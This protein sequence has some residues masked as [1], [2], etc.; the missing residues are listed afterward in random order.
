M[1]PRRSAQWYAGNDRNSYI[2]RAWMRRGL[3]AD[4]FDGRPH[5]AIANTASDL[6][7]C[8]AHLDEV[9]RSVS[10]GIYEAGGIALNLPVVSL[11][12]TQVRP[13]AMLW[14]N[15]AAMATEEMLRANPIDGV[16]LLGGCDKTIPSLLMAAA[17]VD[18]PAVVMP[19]GPMLTGTFR[20]VPLGCGTG[21]WQLS[22]E[23]RA[24]TLSAAEFVRSES[25]MI[26]S[27][28]HCNTMGTASTMGLLAEVLGMTRP[29]VAGIPAPDSRLLEAAHATGVLVVEMIEAG[30]RPSTVLSRGSFLNAIVALAALGGSTNAVVHL[31]AIAGRLGVELT[32]DDFDRTGSHV[33]LLVDLQPAGRFLME[34]LY[35]A[36]GLH[37]VLNEVR[38]L[39]DPAA[40]TVTGRPLVEHLDTARVYDREVI[41]PREQPLQ[42]AAGI[43]VLY[44]NLAPDGA[45]I[46]PAAASPELLSHRGPA[47]VFD[48]IEDLHA[49]LDDP[50]LG[51]TADSVLILRGCGPKGYPGM[52]EVA[53]LP[54]PAKLLAEGVRDMVRICDGRMSGTAYG[55]V[56]LHVTPE[57]AVGGPLAKVR[58]GDMI[59]L[60]VA[61]RRLD[62][63]IPDAELAAREPAAAAVNAFA[64]PR[65]GWERLYVDTVGQAN[66]GADLDFLLGSSGDEVSRESH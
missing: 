7:P 57:A 31:L 10:D 56:V 37:A 19:G 42:P 43:A 55:T 60:D 1:Q 62:V 61:G 14:R 24:G 50:D 59:I 35:R 39:L 20:G 8:N 48:S 4:A 52:P 25:S 36:G 17:S 5:I 13:T 32:Q 21:V 9:A 53:N 41:R 3:P 46:K 44:G 38:D 51:V 30:R 65:R 22:E 26:R 12:E 6:T 45:V 40:L 47:V 23:V 54:L 11:G 27:K 28:G 63:D 49:R 29:G 2:H 64:R 34:D 58:T 66:I 15:M 16:V 33:P 18:L